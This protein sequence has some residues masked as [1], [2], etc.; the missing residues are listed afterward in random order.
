MNLKEIDVL[1][2]PTTF[3]LKEHY[4]NLEENEEEMDQ[5]TLLQSSGNIILS[6]LYY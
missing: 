3:K 5:K 4:F 1:Y 2:I 6:P